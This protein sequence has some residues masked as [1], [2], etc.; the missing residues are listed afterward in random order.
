[1]AALLLVSG[2]EER[3]SAPSLD[4]VLL[5]AGRVASSALFQISE[6]GLGGVAI[7]RPEPVAKGGQYPF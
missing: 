4:W 5:N 3:F 1:M 6:S 7:Q 2:V